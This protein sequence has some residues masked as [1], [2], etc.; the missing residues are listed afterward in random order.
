VRKV[1]LAIALCA[2][3][4]GP[5]RWARA[6]DLWMEG[7]GDKVVLRAGHRGGE[8]APIGSSRIQ[9]R[10][11]HPGGQTSVVD[12]S[13][14]GLD[15]RGFAP[16]PEDQQ[17]WLKGPCE[18]AS[19]AVDQGFFVVT[20]DGEKRRKKSE[21]PDAVRSWRSRQFAKWVDVRSAAATR[22]L[23]D[24]LEILP[25]TDLAKARVGDKVTVRVVLDGRPTAGAVVAIGHERL[26]ETS[27]SGEARVA[28]RHGGLETISASVTR[29]LGTPDADSDVLE[30]TL[31]F[32]VPR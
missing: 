14:P 22:P 17:I 28:V 6:H 29:P 31:S 16:T 12:L 13:T 9:T 10:C 11:V 24:A 5:A 2:A 3:A 20:P 8:S 21:A 30:A 7:A 26:A 25:V 27:S 18:A 19:A 23:G 15:R 1:G 32:E 4:L